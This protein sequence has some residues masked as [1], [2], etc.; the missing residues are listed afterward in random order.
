MALVIIGRSDPKSSRLTTASRAS[1]FSGEEESPGEELGD[2]SPGEE[3]RWAWFA[4]L[5]RGGG[6]RLPRSATPPSSGEFEELLRHPG[7]LPS[8][9]ILVDSVEELLRPLV[10]G[11]TWSWWKEEGSFDV[12]GRID[13]GTDGGTSFDVPGRIM[14]MIRNQKNRMIGLIPKTIVQK[15]AE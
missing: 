8:P 15:Q 13:G 9:G 2:D 7:G 5:V 10:C 6:P 4:E 12:P 3:S 11:G 1:L 14:V